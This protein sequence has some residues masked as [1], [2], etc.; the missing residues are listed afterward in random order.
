MCP[1]VILMKGEGQGTDHDH[2]T[3][4]FTPWSMVKKVDQDTLDFA[5]VRW[6]KLTNFDRL[7][8]LILKFWSWSW[9]K[10]TMN[11]D[12]LTTAIWKFWPW[13]LTLYIKAKWSKKRGHLNLTPPPIW[14]FSDTFVEFLGGGG[15]K[16][17]IKKRR[18]PQI[19]N[20][21]L[22]FFVFCF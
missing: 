12:H 2:D 9:S 3:L 18:L 6:S 13:S 22:V 5:H 21:G 4:E 20:L 16:V 10:V 15:G 14:V 1:S 17:A 19:S 11:F 8:T 7:T